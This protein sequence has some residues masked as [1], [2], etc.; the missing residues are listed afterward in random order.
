MEEPLRQ[1]LLAFQ[2]V[3]RCYVGSDRRQNFTAASLLACMPEVL[4]PSPSVLLPTPGS[5]LLP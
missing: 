1:E 4:S 2:P 5:L 3:L